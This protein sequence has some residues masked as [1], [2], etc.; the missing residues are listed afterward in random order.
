MPKPQS[1]QAIN[2]LL[3]KIENFIA[4][5]WSALFARQGQ[6][7]MKP[8]AIRPDTDNKDDRAF[9][10]AFQLAKDL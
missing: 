3:N 9:R 8:A 5:H 2:P 7:A 1:E 4:N 6:A 10:V